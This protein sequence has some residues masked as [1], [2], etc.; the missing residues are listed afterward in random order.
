MRL[1]HLPLVVCLVAVSIVAVA[2]EPIPMSELHFNDPNGAPLM[3]DQIVTIQG[4]I[5]APTGVFNSGRTEVYLQDDTGGMN[6]FSFNPVWENGYELGDEFKVTGTIIVYNGLTELEPITVE[7]IGKGRPQPEPLLV[8]CGELWASYDY[9]TNSEPTESLLIRLNGVTWDSGNFALMDDTGTA[10]MYIDPDTGIPWPEGE[11]NVVGVMKQFDDAGEE[12]P[13]YLGYEVLPRFVGDITYGSGPQFVDLP[14]QTGVAVGSA[15]IA[16]T[17][18]MPCETVLEYGM[19]SGL[20]MDPIALGNST[21]THEVVLT[22]LSSATVYYC[23]AVAAEGDDSINSP[24]IAVVGPS[25]N[26]SGQ[27]EVYFSKSVDTSYSTGVDAVQTNIAQRMVERINAATTSI[28]FCFFAFTHDDVADALV[29]A[30]NRGV[31]VQVIYEV[32]DPVINVLTVAGIEVRTD[33]DEEHENSHNKFAIFDSR[34]GDETNDVVWTGSWNASYNGTDSNAENAV[35]VH[36]AALASAY[37]IE[38]DE[39]WGGAFSRAKADNTPH[40]FLIGGKNVEQ[41]MSPTDGLPGKMEALMDTADTDMFFAIYSFTHDVIFDAIVARFDAGVAVRGVCDAEAAEYGRYQDLADL[42]IDVV[43]DN[44]EQG[45]ADQLMH[46]KYL[47]A[48][49]LPG[50]SDPTIVT[51]SYNWSYSAATYKDENILIIHDATITNI[52]F[53]EW[54]ARYKEGGGTWDIETPSSCTPIYIAAAASFPTNN[55]PWAS[56]LGINNMGDETLTYKLKFLPPG[57]DNNAVEFTEEF[58]LSP[59]ETA[60]YVDV[61]NQFAGEGFGAINVCVSDPDAAGVVSRI[62]TTTDGGT[63]GQGFVGMPGMSLEKLI[64]TGERVRLG[65][66]EQTGTKNNG[67]GFRTNVGFM[68]AGDT[69]ITVNADFYRK[70]GVWL[71]NRTIDLPPYSGGQWNDAYNSLDGVDK[72]SVDLGYIEVWSNDADAMF[73]A[74]ASVIDNTSNDPSTIWPF[75]TSMMVGGDGFECT[76]VWVAAAASFPNNNPVWSSDLSLT[77][78]GADILTYKFQFLPRGEDNSAVAMSDP[79]TL[80][81]NQAVAYSDIWNS[82]TGGQGSGAINVCVDNG[83]TA[84]ISSRIYSIADGTFGQTFGGMRGS[85]PAKVT[86]GEKVRLGYLFQNATFRTNIGFMNAGATE[87]VIF[88][89]FY[90]NEGSYM[91]KKSVTLAPYSNSQ[92]NRAFT[93]DP[94]FG[95]DVEAGFVDV[96]SDTPDAN[97]LTYA[98]IVDNGTGDP[99]TVWPF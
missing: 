97:F 38:F 48:D 54:M 94:I 72:N 70:E 67:N 49:P 30:H 47:M 62:Y 23:S 36:D 22:G 34:D 10:M 56:D 51:G 83:D 45:G 84:G 13:W 76:P 71:G 12:G 21:M 73:L 50:G 98:S 18:D 88:A 17:T 2:Q 35:V 7:L 87:I 52:F 46:H 25:E 95:T 55:P 79:F 74:Y 81:G 41:Y 82:M 91:G 77:N 61:W 89:D 6:L 96:W 65:G 86:T 32:F 29:A 64:G 24:T 40:L 37:R 60:S 9:A 69:M 53:Q 57:V 14:V 3:L 27:I 58:T 33:P 93:L 26:S 99:S 92:W 63:V 8:T 43:L 31:A 39:M 19:T 15:T 11:F 42:G 68:N 78:L 80:G 44:V 4:V 5:T 20:E 1:I 66:L 59:N 85:A 16:W 75:D 90:N 28:D